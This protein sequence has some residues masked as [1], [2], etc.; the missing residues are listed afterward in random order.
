MHR[1][2][3]IDRVPSFLL[4]AGIG[5]GHGTFLRERSFVAIDPALVPRVGMSAIGAA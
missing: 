3:L 5:T 4:D 2:T 1:S